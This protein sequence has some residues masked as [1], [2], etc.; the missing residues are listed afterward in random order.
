MNEP[1]KIYLHDP[2]GYF[3]ENG[4]GDNTVLWSEDRVDDKDYEYIR[5]SKAALADVTELLELIRI[6]PCT[7]KAGY[8]DRKLTDPDCPRCNWIDEDTVKKV[9]EHFT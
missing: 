2:D 8:K 4:L 6:I 7:C 1:D 5:A 3:E 9:N